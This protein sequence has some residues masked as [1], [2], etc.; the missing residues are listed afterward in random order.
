MKTEKKVIFP[1]TN[2]IK[3][4]A[5]P[6]GKSQRSHLGS[7]IRLKIDG[8]YKKEE[9]GKKKTIEERRDDVRDFHFRNNQ[10]SSKES[11]E[12]KKKK[13]EKKKERAKTSP[14]RKEFHWVVI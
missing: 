11:H 12:K 4:P 3:N 1:P 13:K 7:C 14:K 2:V 6:R 9:K 8:T 5:A 10:N